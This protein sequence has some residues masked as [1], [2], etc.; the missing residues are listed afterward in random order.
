MHVLARMSAI[1][2]ILVACTIGW[3]ILG[4]VTLSRSVAQM[5]RLDASIAS[6]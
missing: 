5:K 4:G 3:W 1:L 2:G 6:L